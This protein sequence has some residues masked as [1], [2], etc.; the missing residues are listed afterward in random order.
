MANSACIENPNGTI[1]NAKKLTLEQTKKCFFCRTKECTAKMIL[2]SRMTDRAHFR[3][4]RIGDH[5]FDKC[6]VDSLN[7][8][9]SAYSEEAFDLDYAIEYIV[10]QGKSIN[11]HNNNRVERRTNVRDI[12]IGGSSNMPIRTLKELYAQCLDTGVGGTYGGVAVNDMLACRRNFEIHRNGFEGFKIVEVTYYKKVYNE[13]ALLFNYPYYDR[14]VNT[15][16]RV[17]FLDSQK[18]WNY[19]NKFKGS[20]HREPM[21]IAGIWE[22]C[23]NSEAICECV[24]YRRNQLFVLSKV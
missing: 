11:I 24:F 5:K 7:F 3:S 1:V 15:V 8:D 14:G 17:N 9:K 13:P 23:N 16:V 22:K 19:Y 10:G 6:I 20:N 2:V 21:V 18:A 4:H 12:N